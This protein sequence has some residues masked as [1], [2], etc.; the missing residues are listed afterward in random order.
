TLVRRRPE[1]PQVTQEI[2]M[3]GG[4]VSWKFRLKMVLGSLT[5]D[6]HDGTDDG[7]Q[8][9]TNAVDDGHKASADGLEDALD[10]WRVSRELLLK[11]IRMRRT[12]ARDD[13]THVDRCYEVCVRR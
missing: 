7:V 9:V 1:R 13:G 2:M 4:I 10:L 5:K 3:S 8:E 12:Y 11:M 6:R